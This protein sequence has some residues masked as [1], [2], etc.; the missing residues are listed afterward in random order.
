MALGAS[1]RN[2]LA[3]ALS[4]ASMVAIVNVSRAADDPRSGYWLWILSN[5][6][7][8]TNDPFLTLE[9]CQRAKSGI[10]GGVLLCLPTSPFGKGPFYI[11]TR[12][13][14]FLERV[15]QSPPFSS[16]DECDVAARPL[17]RRGE[18]DMPCAPE[19]VLEFR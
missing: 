18:Y 4:I 13:G 2:V 5:G 1:L 10:G 11:Y 8:H 17:R 6:E 3:A 9:E 7:A 16:L 12:R 14:D 15:R 19:N